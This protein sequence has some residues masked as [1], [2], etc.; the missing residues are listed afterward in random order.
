MSSG[1][2]TPTSYVDR[3]S[4][5]EREDAYSSEEVVDA[6][7]P[8][9]KRRYGNNEGSFRLLPQNEIGQGLTFNRPIEDLTD[10]GSRVDRAIPDTDQ[11]I[12]FVQTGNGRRTRGVH[13]FGLDPAVAPDPRPRRNRRRR[14]T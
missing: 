2:H 3:G 4:H 6:H 14:A 12:A 10:V 8:A 1:S 5:N 11:D 9:G 7:V 13:S